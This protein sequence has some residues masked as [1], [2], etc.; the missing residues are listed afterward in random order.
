MPKLTPHEEPIAT[1]ERLVADNMDGSLQAT[2]NCN[3]CF[4]ELT[5]NLVLNQIRIGRDKG[6]GVCVWRLGQ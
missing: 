2:A 5:I 4:E 1:I 3:Q 6:D